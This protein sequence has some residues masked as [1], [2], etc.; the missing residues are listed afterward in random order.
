MQKITLFHGGPLESEN[1]GGA[2]FWTWKLPQAIEY[3]DGDGDLYM[4][5]VDKLSEDI[6]DEQDYLPAAGYSDADTS[7]ANWDIQTQAIA[8]AISDGATI[9]LCDDGWAIS[10]AG[11]LNPKKMSI[12]EAESMEEF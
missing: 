6:R 11:R 2:T 4:V 9:V 5:E 10:N 8:D 3:M 1:F 12:E 7:D